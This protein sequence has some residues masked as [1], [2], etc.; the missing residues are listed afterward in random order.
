MITILF[1]FGLLS[2]IGYSHFFLPK[3]KGLNPLIKPT[4]FPIMWNGMIIIPFSSE[5]AIHIHHWLLYLLICI[6]SIYIYIPDIF[7]GFSVGLF[8]QG[9]MYEDFDEFI[10]SNPYN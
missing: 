9:A 5:K 10:C 2:S 6:V 8:L 3:E 1:I 7:I 4:C